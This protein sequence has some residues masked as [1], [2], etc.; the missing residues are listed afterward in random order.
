MFKKIA[1]TVLVIIL[2]VVLIA[3]FQEGTYK[4]QR[5][6]VIQAKAEAINP[7]ISSSKKADEWM[8]W[9]ET[10][11]QVK[12]SYSGP[13]EGLGSTANWESPGQMGTGK[14]E[15]I[16]LIP[17][18]LAKTKITYTKPM[19]FT[20]DSEFSLAPEGDGTKMTWT[21][22]G[23][24]PFIARLMCLVTFMDMDKYVGAQFEKGL[25]KLKN[26]VEKK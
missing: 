14:A 13:E 5:E 20:Q 18:Q 3:A 22:R 11:P 15:I 4:I 26:L 12:M 10:D 8:P 25:Q 21:V 24:K 17:N 9:A 16:E 2:G 7:Y 19:E 6:I 1:F 23:D